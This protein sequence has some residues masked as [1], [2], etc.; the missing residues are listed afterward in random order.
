MRRSSLSLYACEYLLH[1]NICCILCVVVSTLLRFLFGSSNVCLFL[2]EL[3]VFLIM[4]RTMPFDDQVNIS[5]D[6]SSSDVE[7]NGSAG[8]ESSDNIIAVQPTGEILSEGK[9]FILVII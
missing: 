6:D 7:M 3:L 8:K 5:S 2:P 1:V 9:Y 4:K